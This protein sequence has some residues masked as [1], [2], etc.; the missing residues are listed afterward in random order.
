VLL[1]NFN[2]IMAKSNVKFENLEE[3]NVNSYY[4]FTF[5]KLT[6]RT[7]IFKKSKNKE[8]NVASNTEKTLNANKGN[9]IKIKRAKMRR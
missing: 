6:I 4:S 3:K 5:L 9:N 2:R 7:N 8:N 1:F